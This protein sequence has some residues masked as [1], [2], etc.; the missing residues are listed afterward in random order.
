MRPLAALLLLILACFLGFV[1]IPLAIAAAAAGI[2]L[3]QRVTARDED[4]FV[5]LLGVLAG[6]AILYELLRQAW[7]AIFT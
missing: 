3:G 5:G 7:I 2:A 1:S 4:R 6:A